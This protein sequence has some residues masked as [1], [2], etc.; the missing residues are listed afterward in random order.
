[1]IP[2]CV[3]FD[4]GA[5]EYYNKKLLAILAVSFKHGILLCNEFQ[6]WGTLLFMGLETGMNVAYTKKNVNKS[7]R[8]G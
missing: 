2:P 7:A 6:I 5:S 8:F 4:T 1:M 3:F